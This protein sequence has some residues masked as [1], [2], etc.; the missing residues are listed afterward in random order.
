MEAHH[1]VSDTKIETFFEALSIF[2]AGRRPS[3]GDIDNGIDVTKVVDPEARIALLK[4][5]RE[6][7]R[8]KEIAMKEM[9]VGLKLF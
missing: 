7:E 8:D 6:K 5:Q 3:N 9:Q 2:K 1:L 4:A